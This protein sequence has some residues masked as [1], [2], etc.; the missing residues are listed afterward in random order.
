M[1]ANYARELRVWTAIWCCTHGDTQSQIPVI[2]IV[3]TFFEL[4]LWS[5]EVEEGAAS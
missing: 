4:T 1:A 2:A 3:M 5:S